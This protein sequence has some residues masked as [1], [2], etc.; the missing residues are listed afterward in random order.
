MGWFSMVD[1]RAYWLWLQGCLKPG[2]PLPLWVLENFPGGAEGF[3]QGGPKAWSSLPALSWADFGALGSFSLAEAQNR[4]SRAERA[5]WQVIVLEDGAYPA[6]LR[7]IYGPPA[8]LYVKGRLPDFSHLPAVAVVGSRRPIAQSAAAA[9]RFGAQLAESGMIIVG[10][11]AP[12]VDALV[13][14]S[15]IEK[16]DKLVCVLPVD[17]DSQYPVD[18]IPL[19]RRILE[20]GGALVT[21]HFSWPKPISGSF[22]LRNRLITG[23]CF[24]V[25]LIQAAMRSGTL[26]YATLAAGQGRDVFVY[27]GPVESPEYLGTRMLLG[28]GAAPVYK[29]EDVL[30]QCPID[31]LNRMLQEYTQQAAGA[32]GEAGPE[33]EVE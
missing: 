24:G 27:P 9:S 3:Y 11:V 29:G 13:M 5:G 10:G 16:T 26:M 2:S 6:P 30:A 4:L 33:R 14:A 18:T 21:E 8:V 28:E 1:S 19:R 15:A 20:R 25:V 7:H 32:F 31:F 22:H 17:L 23:L 12:G